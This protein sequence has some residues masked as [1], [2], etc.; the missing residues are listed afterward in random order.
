MSPPIL[1]IISVDPQDPAALE[2]LRAAAVEARQLYPE[3]HPPGSAW[4]TNP[5]LPSGGAYILACLDGTPVGCG[6][7]R[8]IDG[9]F[10]EVRRMF[11]VRAARRNG[12]ARAI[13]ARLEQLAREL[14]YGAMRLETGFRQHAA[15]ALYEHCGYKRIAP[16]GEYV[17][18][19]TSICFE[20]HL[21]GRGRMR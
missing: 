10:V 5:P 15:T 20:K 9:F 18:D 6:A 7:L 16:F 2:L 14:G 4:P 3:L 12:V 1:Q 11:V 19:P 21:S 13:L 17:D 8:P